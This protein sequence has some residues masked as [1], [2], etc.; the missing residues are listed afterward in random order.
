MPV[1]DNIFGLGLVGLGI[2]ALTFGI[3]VG[4]PVW[5]YHRREILRMRGTAAKDVQRLRER[6]EG[7]EKRCAKLEEQVASA[8]ML[9][10]DEQRQLDKKLSNLVP[11]G[12]TIPDDVDD[13]AGRSKKRERARD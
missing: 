10:A 7:L 1:L 5:L 9:I 13:S 6:I 2:V 3:L 12:A 8:H 4:F 11:G